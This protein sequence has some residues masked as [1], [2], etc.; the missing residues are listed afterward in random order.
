MEIRGKRV[1]ITGANRGL[2]QALALAC[3]RADAGEVFAGTRNLDA[4]E[5]LAGPKITPVKL[6]V[7]SD[8]D[9]SSAVDRV[10]RIDI[11]INNAGIAV[12]GGVFKASF[13]DIQREIE[14]NVLGPLRIA[15]AFAPAMVEHGDGLIVNVSSQLSKVALPATGTYCATKAA[16]LMLTQAM[17]GDLSHRG[18]RVIAVLPGA[19]DTDMTRNYD[20]PKTSPSRV[21]EEILDAIKTE[22]PETAVSDDARKLLSDLAADPRTVEEALAQF[23]A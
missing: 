15:R 16:L 17:R 1:L 3:V 12:Y 2:G 13:D 9:V 22:A 7:T 4:F 19:M 21:A 10:G 20:I 6:D 18:V 8:E 5:A 14:V 11:L 23:R